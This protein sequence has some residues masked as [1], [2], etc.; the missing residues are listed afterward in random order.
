VAVT[1]EFQGTVLVIV[2]DGIY[3]NQDVEQ[4]VTQALADPRFEAGMQ[5]MMDA[6]RSQTPLSSADIEWRLDLIESLPARGLVPRV[7]YLVQERQR[8]LVELVS[9]EFQSPKPV[10]SVGIGFFTDKS[11]A[12]AWLQGA[13]GQPDPP[14]NRGLAQR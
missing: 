13:A 6:R 10:L 2:L 1:W 8:T 11:Q 12:I 14:L 5:L 4:G 3:A 9:R 7:A